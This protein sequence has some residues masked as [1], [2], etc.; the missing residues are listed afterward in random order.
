MKYILMNH[1][2]KHNTS[3]SSYH[4]TDLMRVCTQNS[5]NER[6]PHHV[7][8]TEDGILQRSLGLDEVQFSSVQLCP[9]LCDPMDYS[10]PGFPILHQLPELT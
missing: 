10:M 5:Y 7:I 6:Y 9:T 8:I 1:C 4:V 3:V 2:H